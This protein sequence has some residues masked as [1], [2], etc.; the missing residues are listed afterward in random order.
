MTSESRWGDFDPDFADDLGFAL[1]LVLAVVLGRRSLD[2][3]YPHVLWSFLA[4]LTFNLGHIIFLRRRMRALDRS[5]LSVFGNT[6]LLT[7]VVF[8]SGGDGS[9]LW[10]MY[11]LPVFTASL[12]LSRGDFL[13]TVTAVILFLIL[14]HVDAPRSAGA[15]GLLEW[16][17]KAA[18]IAVSAAALRRVARREKSAK[19]MLQEEQS[20]IERERSSMRQSMQ[21][22]D[23]LA[24]LGTLT[25]S[26]THELKNPLNTV[27]GYSELAEDGKLSAAELRDAMEH[28]K[29][30][31]L[32][33]DKIIQDM[34]AFSR[35]KKAPRELCDINALSR[36]CV[37]LKK[38][39]WFHAGV[40]ISEE[41][42]L[43][44]PKAF[45][46]GP[47]FQ[48]VL[49]NLLVNAQQAAGAAGRLPVEIRLR[50][51]AQ[52]GRV[53]VSVSDNGP[54]IP[55]EIL[56]KIWE[57][58]FTTKPS[59]EGTGLGLSICKQLVE[60]QGGTLSAASAPGNGATFT[61]A[62]PSMRVDTAE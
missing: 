43:A 23:R 34:L 9:F 12:K 37:S 7:A 11:L 19:A 39:D 8:Y 29:G 5:R 35:K 42:D 27:L 18:T 58:F 20:R 61:V 25:A 52:D 32:R 56:N 31:V 50:S 16:F 15:Q 41:Y 30:A 38:V 51:F 62:L 24:T 48:Q 60:A 57:P 22:M 3:V 13:G 4:L 59:G 54:G 6:A 14:F 55:P 46:A 40:E 28:I 45:A 26:I 2:F 10:V 1:I 36:E 17:I 44:L 49:F 33:C 21:H 47:E 53:L